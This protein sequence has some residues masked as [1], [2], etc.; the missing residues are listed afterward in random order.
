MEMSMSK[1]C[2]LFDERNPIESR[3]HLNINKDALKLNEVFNLR[4]KRKIKDNID[5]ISVIERVKYVALE[6]SSLT[7]LGLMKYNADKDRFDMTEL[8]SLLSGGISE[9]VRSL[10]ERL[11]KYD[12]L[13]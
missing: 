6:G 4:H 3:T 8:A 2:I 13:M 5:G 10:Q 1:N 9:T 11:D 12:E 7:L